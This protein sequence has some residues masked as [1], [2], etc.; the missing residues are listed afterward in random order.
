[1]AQTLMS[2]AST[3]MSTR[4]GSAPSPPFSEIFVLCCA[5]G[6]ACAAFGGTGSF[7]GLRHT[8]RERLDTNVETADTSVCATAIF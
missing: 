4:F 7:F 1:M 2:A 5:R 8:V 6:K 3:L